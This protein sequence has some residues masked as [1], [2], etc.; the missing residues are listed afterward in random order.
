MKF[1]SECLKYPKTQITSKLSSHLLSFCYDYFLYFCNKSEKN[2]HY[3]RL[4][5]Q[6]H[7]HIQYSYPLLLF[8][9][10]FHLKSGTI[11]PEIFGSRCDKLCYY[12]LEV[13]WE[14]LDPDNIVVACYPPGGGV[15]FEDIKLEYFGALCCKSNCFFC[16]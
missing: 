15:A 13:G 2:P 14:V 1:F 12:L 5:I 4:L 7:K 11:N 9:S 8:L 3:F 10:F 6:T 16:Y